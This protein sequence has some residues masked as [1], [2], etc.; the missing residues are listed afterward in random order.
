MNIAASLHVP[1]APIVVVARQQL[2]HEVDGP[3]RGH[4]HIGSEDYPPHGPGRLDYEPLLLFAEGRMRPGEGF[5]LHRHEGIENLII[6]LDGQMRHGDLQGNSWL[7]APGDAYLMSAGQGGEHSEFVEGDVEV[8]ALVIWLRSSHPDAACRHHR[9]HFGPDARRDR[10]VD[11]AS[12]DS[13]GESLSMPLQ[14]DAT[15]RATVLSPGASVEHEVRPGRRAYL[16]AVQ[17][18]VEINGRGV[19]P[20]DRVLAP[21]P[22]RI[23]CFARGGTGDVELVLVDMAFPS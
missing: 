14:A 18:G 4:A 10:W 5:P 13:G 1:P 17:G 2:A 15:V 22:G 20:G 6:V 23:E 11:L 3:T 9:R 8:H 7:A 12:S 21:G 19:G 16:I